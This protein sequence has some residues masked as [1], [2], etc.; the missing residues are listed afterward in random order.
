M[1]C[2]LEVKS[3][4]HRIKPGSSSH[5]YVPV[6]NNIEQEMTFQKRK[7]LGTIQ[8]VQSVTPLTVETEE[9]LVEGEGARN[10]TVNY[11]EEPSKPEQGKMPWA[12]PVD[13]SHL[14]CGQNEGV[15]EMLRNSLEPLLW[16]MMTLDAFK[17]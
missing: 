17:T 9:S 15:R 8:L 13:L 10:E 4:L 12:P 1:G 16:M 3:C 6:A 7:V 5:I 2:G 14:S 11:E